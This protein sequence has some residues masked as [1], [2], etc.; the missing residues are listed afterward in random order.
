MDF[1]RFRPPTSDLSAWRLVQAVVK[2]FSLKNNQL[3]FFHLHVSRP[4]IGKAANGAVAT[5]HRKLNR[6]SSDHSI[7]KGVFSVLGSDWFTLLRIT[8]GDPH[9][10]R[11]TARKRCGL[12][13]ITNTVAKSTLAS[14]EM[15]GDR[16]RNGSCWEWRGSYRS[17]IKRIENGSVHNRRGQRQ[18]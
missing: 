1:F 7:R 13:G 16:V 3:Q 2:H 18:P 15:G 17:C 12:W 9:L 4:D 6:K 14:R 5:P 11:Y 10:Y 8:N